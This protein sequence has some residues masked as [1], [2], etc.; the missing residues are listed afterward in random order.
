MKNAPAA[1]IARAP[2]GA[3]NQCLISDMYFLPPPERMHPP[4]YETTKKRPSSRRLFALPRKGQSHTSRH[5]TYPPGGA[6]RVSLQ[7]C[8]VKSCADAKHT[9]LAQLSIKMCGRLMG[10][11]ISAVRVLLI[12]AILAMACL[13]GCA[14][15]SEN[16][17]PPAVGPPAA[18]SESTA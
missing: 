12:A 9:T 5:L 17:E 16:R 6:N 4:N 10:K 1:A 15:R 18:S 14:S 7:L 11:S 8:Y 2:I 13:C 3:V